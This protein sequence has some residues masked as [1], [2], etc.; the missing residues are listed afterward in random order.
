MRWIWALGIAAAAAFVVPMVLGPFAEAGAL[1]LWT[2]VPAAGFVLIA[3]VW[4]HRRL[5]VRSL[6]KAPLLIDLERRMIVFR[7]RDADAGVHVEVPFERLRDVM[8]REDPLGAT[9]A[10]VFLDGKDRLQT[11]DL[12]N[13]NLGIG[14]PLSRQEVHRY[15]AWLKSVLFEGCGAPHAVCPTDV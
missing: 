14:F 2:L 13:P 5:W 6:K 11:V 4:G 8:V 10:I 9:A 3:G 1:P 12:A 7:P 15:A